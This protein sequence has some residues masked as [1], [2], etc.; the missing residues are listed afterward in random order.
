MAA[1]TLDA[2]K[3]IGEAIGESGLPKSDTLFLSPVFA[4]RKKA[5]R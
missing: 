3:A 5:L 4:A 2:L 1:T